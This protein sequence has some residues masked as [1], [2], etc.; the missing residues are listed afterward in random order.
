MWQ[1][2]AKLKEEKYKHFGGK[3]WNKADPTQAGPKTATTKSARHKELKTND[4][5]ISHEAFTVSLTRREIWVLT[6]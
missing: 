3:K 1:F 5:F 6:D 4:F 2:Q